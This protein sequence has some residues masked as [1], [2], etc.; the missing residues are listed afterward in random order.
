MLITCPLGRIVQLYATDDPS[1]C[2]PGECQSVLASGVF[3]VGPPGSSTL[4]PILSL[5]GTLSFQNGPEQAI[6]LAQKSFFQNVAMPIAPGYP[7]WLQGLSLFCVQIGVGGPGGCGGI[8]VR[9]VGTS[10]Q[11]FYASTATSMQWAA[12]VT[13]TVTP[14]ITQNPLR[15]PVNPPKS[16][17][18]TPQPTQSTV[19]PSNMAGKNLGLEVGVPVAAALAVWIVR[20]E[21]HRTNRHRE[22]I[23]AGRVVFDRSSHNPV[24]F[25]R[26][27]RTVRLIVALYPAP[28]SAPLIPAFS[29]RSA[30]HFAKPIPANEPAT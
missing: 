19:N 18:F 15:P 9:A 12:A 28:A 8:G 3:T 16:P 24:R 14:V 22:A 4:F 13:F 27:V 23:P 20:K 25:Y 30:L 17:V 2:F 26:G 7:L 1:V 11:G 21:W 6:T 5:S 29:P 10:N